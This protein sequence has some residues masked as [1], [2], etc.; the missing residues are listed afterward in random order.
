[1]NNHPYEPDY[2][3]RISKATADR[4]CKHG[5]PAMGWEVTIAE[6]EY[7]TLMVQNISG[8][9]YVASVGVAKAEWGAVFGIKV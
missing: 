6:N 1:M 8:T 9:L 2:A 5:A 3:H 4:L 7:V